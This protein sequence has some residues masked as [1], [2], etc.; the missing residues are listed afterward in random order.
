M[1]DRAPKLLR[2]K[3]KDM[4]FTLQLSVFE[5]RQIMLSLLALSRRVPP[6]AF[7]NVRFG[8]DES[9]LREY[10]VRANKRIRGSRFGRVGAQCHVIENRV[11][12][13]MSVLSLGHAAVTWPRSRKSPCSL[14]LLCSWRS[15]RQALLRMFWDSLSESTGLR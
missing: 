10:D 12:S 7:I 11:T 14:T 9:N 3:A 2:A 4:R 6:P 5:D 1:L 8:P 13:W 15:C